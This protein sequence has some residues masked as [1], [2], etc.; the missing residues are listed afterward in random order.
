MGMMGAERTRECVGWDEV[1][2]DPNAQVGVAAKFRARL[3]GALAHCGEHV[4]GPTSRAKI[5]R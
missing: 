1:D 3:P 4:K 5:S 2:G